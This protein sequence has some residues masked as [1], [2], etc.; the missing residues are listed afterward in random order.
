MSRVAHELQSFTPGLAALHENPADS[1]SGALE[2]VLGSLELLPGGN[3]LTPQ[4]GAV[5]EGCPFPIPLAA[6]CTFDGIFC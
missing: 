6:F 4:S 5:C 3:G 2:K 1:S